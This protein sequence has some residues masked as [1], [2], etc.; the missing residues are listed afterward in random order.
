[1]LPE[2]QILKKEKLGWMPQPRLTL[3]ISA[4]T[5]LRRSRSLQPICSGKYCFIKKEGD[6]PVRSSQ[7]FQGSQTHDVCQNRPERCGHQAEVIGAL[8]KPAGNKVIIILTEAWKPRIN[9]HP[10]SSACH[11]TGLLP[12]CAEGVQSPPLPCHLSELPPALNS[13]QRPCPPR[14]SP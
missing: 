8:G 2:E 11:M 10:M 9:K 5:V 14:A 1:M 3:G 4:S 7:C 6:G 13:R 12:G